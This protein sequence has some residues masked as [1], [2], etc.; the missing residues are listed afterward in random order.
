MAL[1]VSRV[2]TDLGELLF[3]T[4][5]YTTSDPQGVFFLRVTSDFKR[6]NYLI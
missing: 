1:T 3:H 5:P 4:K 2:N 6:S